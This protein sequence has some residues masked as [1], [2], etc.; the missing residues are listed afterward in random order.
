MHMGLVHRMV[1]ESCSQYF[2][3]MRRRV[4]Q[5]PRSFLSF[6]G[7][8]KVFARHTLFIS[9]YEHISSNITIHSECAVCWRS[10]ATSQRLLCGPIMGYIYA[11]REF[12]RGFQLHLFRFASDVPDRRVERRMKP[13]HAAYAVRLSYCTIRM[14]QNQYLTKKEEVD[15]K[16]RRVMVGLDKL[17]KGAND[18]EL[19]KV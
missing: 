13:T 4:Y 1:V 6:L 11:W 2:M 10:S 16:S 3:K 7:S 19:M 18:V 9:I 5:T 8:Y 14:P 15:V 12:K 17:K